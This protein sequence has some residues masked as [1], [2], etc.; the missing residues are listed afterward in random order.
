MSVYFVAQIKII[1]P[2]EY[3]NYLKQ[4][5]DVFSNF[6]GKYLAVDPQP[7]ILEGQWN[8]SRSVI[9]EFPSEEELKRWYE[10][11]A[12]Q[13]ILKH[14]LEGAECNTIVVHGK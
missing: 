3:D 5:D 12:Y 14:R 6:E 2:V 7:L 9:I 10:S 1:D 8:Y 11:E 4:C 13:N